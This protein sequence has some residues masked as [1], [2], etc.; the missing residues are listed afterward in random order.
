MVQYCRKCGKELSDDAEFCD[1]CGFQLDENLKNN[2]Q[3][4]KQDSEN[5]NEFVKKLPLILAIIG[6]IVSIAEGLGTPMLMGW[7]NI[8]TAM[9][10]GIVGGLIGILL[11][12]KLD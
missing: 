6:I 1:G 2:T 7:N 5:K 4:V 11:M 8:L 9:G 10:I 12:E 3:V